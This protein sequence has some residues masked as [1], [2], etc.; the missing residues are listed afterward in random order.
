MVYTKN[1]Y[2]KYLAFLVRETGV[3]LILLVPC[4]SITCIKFYGYNLSRHSEEKSAPRFFGCEV[5]KFIWIII[6]F[7]PFFSIF[8]QSRGISEE[9]RVKSEKFGLAFTC[10]RAINNPINCNTNLNFFTLHFSLFTYIVGI[11]KKYVEYVDYVDNNKRLNAKSQS[12]KVLFLL[13]S[14]ISA[15]LQ[16]WSVPYAYSRVAKCLSLP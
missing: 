1:P 5:N 11:T 12:R 2:F 15:P 8:L 3:Y 7:P 4:D 14:I 13:F 9:I 6:S 16:L 10:E